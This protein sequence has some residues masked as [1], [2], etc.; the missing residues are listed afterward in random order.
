[1]LSD[2]LDTCNSVELTAVASRAGRGRVGLC[3]AA[4]VLALAAYTG[5]TAWILST[6]TARV[7]GFPISHDPRTV[8]EIAMQVCPM[9][10]AMF[11]VLLAPVSERL[12]ESLARRV[13]PVL[14]YRR[15][16][17]TVAVSV[18]SA[19]VTVCATAGAVAGVCGVRA[20]APGAATLLW[21]AGELMFDVALIGVFI[22]TLH[23]LTRRL[24][25]T[26]LLFLLYIVTVSV[27]GPLWGITSYI[28][29][30]SSVPVMLTTY[31]TAPLYDGAAWLLRGYWLCVTLLMLSIRY[32]YDCPPLPLLRTLV[33]GLREPERRWRG[34]L[35]VSLALIALCILAG[36]S[37]LRLQRYGTAR[38]QPP[39]QAA[40]DTALLSGREE[41]RLHLTHF[42]V[43]LSYAPD[44]RKVAVEGD[45]TFSNETQPIHTAHFQMP[46]L[47]IPDRIEFQGVGKYKL[48]ALGKYIQVTFAETVPPRQQVRAVY[49]GSIEPAG[50][51]DLAVQAKVLQ[52][53][54]FLS[55]SDIL[56]TARRASCL[57]AS[58]STNGCSTS[59]NYLMSDRAAGRI[60][61]IAPERF[62]V[63]SAGE[64]SSR[65]LAGGAREHSITIPT[66]RLVSFMVASAPFRKRTEVLND[67]TRIQVFRSPAATDGDPEGPLAKSILS[68][69]QSAWPAY[70]RHDLNI[71]ETPT[72]LGEALAFDGAIAVSDKII[73][74]RSPVSGTAS[75]LLEFVMAHEIAHQWWGYRVVPTRSPGRLFLLE[76][77]PQFAAYQFLIRRGI[78]SEKDALENERRR[79]GA[80]RARLRSREASLA[81]S[82]T[83]DEL[84]YN[85][86]PFALLSLDRLAGRSLMSRLA[87][88]IDS[89]SYESR[90]SVRPDQVIPALIDALPEGSRAAARSLIFGVGSEDN[91]LETGMISR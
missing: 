36:S 59:E 30:G 50:A 91:L 13:Q 53:A 80:A 7:Y 65:Q 62:S 45:L 5:A 66:P 56:L 3:T 18:G 2:R 43:R 75:N 9:L 81:E 17:M 37:L 33:S 57:T 71:I 72:P 55:D 26:V 41:A 90:G 70:S 69:Y 24:W 29:F 42:N 14:P 11:L 76:S 84:V 46:G 89:Y 82:E 23:A 31:S 15:M 86:G 54:F 25:A 39:S 63:A 16:F 34:P 35:G 79:Y 64:E 22:T 58:A 38:Y 20:A 78:L 1:M 27:V 48:R 60:T 51:F 68:F 77:L 52:G 40:L 4:A 87:G 73:A 19:M 74:S 61:V 67:G 44:E 28:G 8:I 6:N 32:G 21:V 12:A 49:T 88:P 85:K 10:A 47:M 83:G